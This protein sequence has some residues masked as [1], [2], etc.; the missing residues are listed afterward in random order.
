[1]M[2]AIVAMAMVSC[3]KGSNYQEQI[4]GKWEVKTYH[5]WIHDLN[6]E[7]PWAMGD[8]YSR[9]ETWNLPDTNYSGYDAAEFNADGTM[10]WHMTDRMVIEGGYADPYINANWYIS[11]DSLM[12][13]E[14]KYAIKEINDGSLVIEDYYR[15]NSYQSHHGWERTN[16]Y[17][18]ERVRIFP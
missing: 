7:D 18:F 5:L 15:V 13:D 12:I 2:V 6:D 3:N 11:G 1:M 9:E 17:A 4:V 10:R 8:S 16:C 14:T